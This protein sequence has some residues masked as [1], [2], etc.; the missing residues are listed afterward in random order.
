MCVCVC[1]CVCAC[2]S[3]VRLFEISLIHI[4]KKYFSVINSESDEEKKTSVLR[5]N[6]KHAYCTKPGV[7]I[8][9]PL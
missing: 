7:S 2:E 3:D 4:V 1:V 6:L 9:S 5:F 8:Y